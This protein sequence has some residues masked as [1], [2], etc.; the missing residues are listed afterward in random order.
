M[1]LVDSLYDHPAKSTQKEPFPNLEFNRPSLCVRLSTDGV[2]SYRT[3]RGEEYPHI[4][5]T[6]NDKPSSKALKYGLP[7]IKNSELIFYRLQFNSSKIWY[8]KM[9]YVTI[10]RLF[11][12]F[13]KLMSYRLPY[14]KQYMTP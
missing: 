13:T 3:A 10:Y 14:I 9:I 2:C 1:R 4:I 7:F 11:K 8:T 6:L 12:Q 5:E